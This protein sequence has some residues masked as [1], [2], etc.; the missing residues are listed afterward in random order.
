MH[1]L[2]QDQHG[3]GQ[4]G[5]DWVRQG[6]GAAGIGAVGIGAANSLLKQFAQLK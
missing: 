5:R 1:L 2:R 4:C 6:L 3:K